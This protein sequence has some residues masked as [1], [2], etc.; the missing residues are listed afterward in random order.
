MTNIRGYSLG[1]IFSRMCSTAKLGLLSVTVLAR[2]KETAMNPDIVARIA[3]IALLSLTTIT[4]HEPAA[5]QTKRQ[6]GEAT[7]ERPAQQSE[8]CY[9][10]SHRVMP[11]DNIP[12]AVRRAH[13]RELRAAG[14]CTS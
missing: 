10:K 8:T 4:L 11:G 12:A 2:L 6:R 3:A 1:V 5:A 13:I 7:G 9:N 14:G